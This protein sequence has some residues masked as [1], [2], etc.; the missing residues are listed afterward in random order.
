MSLMK[1]D[2]GAQL[3]AQ[4]QHLRTVQARDKLYDIMFTMRDMREKKINSYLI[5]SDSFC[6]A[7][8]ITPSKKMVIEND[9]G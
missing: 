7:Q 9:A 6:T 5:Q 8:I 2:A 3:N 1:G 4:K